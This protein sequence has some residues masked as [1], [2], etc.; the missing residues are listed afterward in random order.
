MKIRNGHVSN[1]S[2][3]SFIVLNYDMWN[4]S[5]DSILTPEQLEILKS[6]GFKRT[7]TNNPHQIDTCYG[8]ID[9]DETGQ[10]LALHWLINHDEI[11]K[12][13]IEAGIPF[14]GTQHYGHW[15]TF[16]D[17]VSEY[18]LFIKNV[19]QEVTLRGTVEDVEKEVLQSIIQ[20]LMKRDSIYNYV[21][22]QEEEQCSH[23]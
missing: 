8:E 15:S 2:T 14:Q 10:N 13:L 9:V 22:E 6:L 4:N 3:S 20:G 12:P 7:W 16:Y 5:T 18:V 21:P 1:S 11:F 19:G 23:L 17:G